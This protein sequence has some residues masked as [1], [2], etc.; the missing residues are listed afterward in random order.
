MDLEAKLKEIEATASRLEAAL[1]D[2][3]KTLED[4]KAQ[5]ATL[6]NENK[7]LDKALTIEKEKALAAE[8][9]AREEGEAKVAESIMDGILAE[10]RIPERLYGKVKN[11]I[12]YKSF[13]GE[14]EPFDEGAD[15][16]NRF[17]AAFKAEVAEWEASIGNSPRIGLNEAKKDGGSDDAD[18][19]EYARNLA[20]QF[21][22]HIRSDENKQ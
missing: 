13:K 5:V 21:A 10:S 7:E 11:Q 19:S 9:K 17:A 20:R 4:L 3:E 22:G 15:A 16:A 6:A 1:A 8:T 2:R 18:F 14:N 12:D